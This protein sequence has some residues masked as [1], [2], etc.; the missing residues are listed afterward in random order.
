MPDKE[1]TKFK[2][3]WKLLANEDMPAEAELWPWWKLDSA[4][5]LF[6][7]GIVKWSPERK[8]LVWLGKQPTDNQ[9]HWN[10]CIRC[11]VVI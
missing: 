5:R 9:D 11:E 4:M 7:A 6:A 10:D 3:R 2:E 8:R 1:L